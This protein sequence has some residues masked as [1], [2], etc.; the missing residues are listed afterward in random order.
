MPE[1]VLAYE[2]LQTTRHPSPESGFAKSKLG[3]R[4]CLVA[5]PHVECSDYHCV[6]R[7]LPP[8]T[9]SMRGGSHIPGMGWWPPKLRL[10]KS[11]LCSECAA[12]D[13]TAVFNPPHD[14]KPEEKPWI[15]LLERQ[16]LV[17]DLNCALCHC[18]SH[19]CY[20]FEEEGIYYIAF[21][22]QPSPPP[23]LAKVCN[24][25]TEKEPRSLD[26]ILISV[27]RTPSVLAVLK[28]FQTNCFV[29]SMVGQSGQKSG[30]IVC[31]LGK[32]NR[33]PR[34]PQIVPKALDISLPK[35]WLERCTRR[36]AT[37]RCAINARL[38]MPRTRL[39]DCKSRKLIN[40]GVWPLHM[41]R[42]AAL[43]YRWGVTPE[44]QM[45]QGQEGR[46]ETK[47]P[48]SN[49]PSNLP[50]TIE[51]AI[52][53]TKGL[54]LRY[55]WVDQY[56]IDQ[57]N[58]EEKQA[59]IQKMD[60]IYQ[61]AEV[62]IMAAAGQDCHYGLPGVSKRARRV[63]EPFILDDTLTFGMFPMAGEHWS[64]SAWNERGWTFQETYL[65]R[66]RLVFS[67]TLAHFECAHQ[68]WWQRENSGGFETV[69]HSAIKTRKL[70]ASYAK[71]DH[72]FHDD[73][74]SW[75]WC[76]I[77]PLISKVSLQKLA[78]Y[79]HR[80]NFEAC[81][82]E[83]YSFVFYYTTRKLSYASDSL[84]AF[85]GLANAMQE[86]RPS[87][88]NVAGIPFM[89]GN[90]RI[91]R[92]FWAESSFSS[93]LA[94]VSINGTDNSD[95]EDAE[96]A[97]TPSWSWGNVKLWPIQIEGLDAHRP[98]NYKA[99]P[100][101]FIV[102]KQKSQLRDI[103]IEFAFDG[104]KQVTVLAEY[105]EK[106]DRKG[107]KKS[108]AQP[109]ALIFKARFVPSHAIG[110][111]DDN[112][113]KN[114]RTAYSGE[115]WHDAHGRSKEFRIE[116]VQDTSDETNRY[117]Q[118]DLQRPIWDSK[119]YRLIVHNKNFYHDMVESKW[120]LLMLSCLTAPHSIRLL[121]IKGV[122]GNTASRVGTI[123][124]RPGSDKYGDDEGVA[125][126]FLRCFTDEREV[127]LV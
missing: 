83:Y 117:P 94:W 84:N 113:E 33:E 13:F 73:M 5:G 75:E 27:L 32:P 82:L 71:I 68:K 124:V 6:H 111:G 122:E 11:D 78:T 64:N 88:Y 105:A 79:S 102:L 46:S 67:D 72:D 126:E 89:V 28:L 80:R 120:S 54:G 30:S 108:L 60:R 81:I 4:R 9:G 40:V 25:E 74:K 61:C 77:A 100:R 69:Q 76:D 38:D 47:G 55:L 12:I 50:L 10:K 56:C 18:F 91:D 51:D 112:V 103:R 127:R 29:G 19:T 115:F 1:E 34:T 31:H 44:P 20:S 95:Q 3:F 23:P 104:K 36:H 90:K 96:N 119:R 98:P 21:H 123:L 106:C 43:S 110:S 70:Q 37:C 118:V 86:L 52:S 114:E 26:K 57:N 101:P 66:R 62:A 8:I 41:P 22:E 2:H 97:G 17:T 48:L 107:F 65:P 7:H 59:Q 49:L 58:V 39:I 93:G 45:E 85:L 53:V 42:F 15:L 109:K 99:T 63:L 121:V 16:Q 116:L 35:A 24:T 125:G 87:I 14:Y 92:D